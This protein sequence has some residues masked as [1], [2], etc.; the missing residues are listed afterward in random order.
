LPRIPDLVS[1]LIAREGEGELQRLMADIIRVLAIYVG[2]SWR[3]ELIPDLT[4]L[5]SFQGRVEA[6]D[7]PLLD[8]ALRELKARGLITIEARTR[9]F[10]TSPKT[11]TDWLIRLTDLPSTI[12]VLREDQTFMAYLK[13]RVMSM[14][15]AA[16]RE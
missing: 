2:V 9:G 10:L 16:D 14:R 6:V 8:R 7:P 3:S 15:G 11:Y 1:D 13:A 4:K 12:D 5:H